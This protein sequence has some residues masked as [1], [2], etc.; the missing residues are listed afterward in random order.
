VIH[1]WS[2]HCEDSVHTKLTRAGKVFADGTV[3]KM[4]KLNKSER[5]AI[6]ERYAHEMRTKPQSVRTNNGNM[7]TKPQSVPPT[8][9]ILSSTKAKP[10]IPKTEGNTLEG[11]EEPTAIGDTLEELG[12]SDFKAFEIPRPSSRKEL[13]KALAGFHLVSCNTDYGWVTWYETVM[14]RYE[15]KGCSLWDFEELLRRVW[16]ATDPR[17]RQAKDLGEFKDPDLWLSKQATKLL[18]TVGVRWPDFPSDLRRRPASV[19][20]GTRP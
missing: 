18:K 3:P 2:E 1:D 9:P 11:R 13:A 19:S 7:R 12:G 10:S 17:T 5:R 14:A 8:K 20:G 15:E 16:D 4:T 6:Q